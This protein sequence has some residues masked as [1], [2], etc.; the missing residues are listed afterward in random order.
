V[1]K[2]FIEGGEIVQNSGPDPFEV[3]DA[4]TILSY[5]TSK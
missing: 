5:L 2:V 4:D 3:T 1:E